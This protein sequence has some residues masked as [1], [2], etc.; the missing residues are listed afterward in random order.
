MH[1]RPVRDRPEAGFRPVIHRLRG[2]GRAARLLLGQWFQGCREWASALHREIPDDRATV[3]GKEDCVTL[4]ASAD[5][6]EAGQFGEVIAD[7]ADR[8]AA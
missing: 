5:Q 4:V 1:F 3:G 8:L 6:A 2:P 7:R